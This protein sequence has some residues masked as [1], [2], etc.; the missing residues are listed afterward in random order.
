MET[1]LDTAYAPTPTQAVAMLKAVKGTW[2]L[3][4]IGGPRNGGHG[5]TP[6]YVKTLVELGI[7]KFL[8]CFVGRQY[9]PSLG[10]YDVLNAGLGAS[11][12]A[13]AARIMKSYGFAD[14]SPVGLDVEYDT[15]TRLTEDAV[16]YADGWCKVVKDAGYNPGVYA[17]LSFL[18][19]LSRETN[20]PKWAF[21]AFWTSSAVKA[22]LDPATIPGLP[23]EAYRGARV[24][25]YG[26]NTS[27]AGTSADID[28]ADIPLAYGPGVEAPPHGSTPTIPSQPTHSPEQY[29]AASR[30]AHLD[31][32]A[33]N[34][35]VADAPARWLEI[36]RYL[37]SQPASKPGN[38]DQSGTDH[39]TKGQA[40]ERQG[41][42]QGEQDD[43]RE[44]DEGE[45]EE[46]GD[47]PRA[48]VEQT[49]DGQTALKNPSVPI[50]APPGKAHLGTP[51]PDTNGEQ[52]DTSGDGGT[53]GEGDHE[54]QGAASTAAPLP[55][56]DPSLKKG[57]KPPVP[58]S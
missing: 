46:Q 25:Q 33:S 8:P 45:G 40:E 23:D 57:S 49:G 11:D 22:G 44:E 50:A 1:G 56:P 9:V 30:I 58:Q 17:P 39:N 37:D 36:E 24:W 26:G 53:S 5:W 32:L 14:G 41:Q 2:W 35:H 12:G 48:G 16:A 47:D 15:A 19:R 3:V 38:G 27:V 54:E 42:G 29:A 51:P 18:Q 34:V 7:K 43:D 31:A 55:K 10:L 13:E 52:V 6:S 21:A 4:Y 28:V 20:R